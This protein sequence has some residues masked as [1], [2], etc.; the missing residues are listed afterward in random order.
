MLE[1][2]TRYRVAQL[3][4][5]GTMTN[6]P[7]RIAP[8]ATS[9]QKALDEITTAAG[10]TLDLKPTVQAAAMLLQSATRL[11]SAARPTD[12]RGSA[13]L[14]QLL[15]RLTHRLNSR[16]Y[17]KA[18]RFDQDP[19]ANV[20][21]LPLLA[22]AR[23]LATMSK[24]SETYGFLET[25]LLRGRNAVEASLTDAGATSISISRRP[26][27]LD[28]QHRIAEAPGLGRRAAASRRCLISLSSREGEDVMRLVGS[29]ILG[30]VLWLGWLLLIAPVTAY[31]QGGTVT[32]TLSGRV[33]DATGG[34]LPGVAVTVVNAGTNQSRT[35]TSS[36]DG[37]FGFAGLTP[38]KYA[39]SAELQGFATFAQTDIVL[40]V[41]AAVDLKV[42]M[43]VSNVSES[44]TVTG[45]SAIVESAKTALTT[46]ISRDQIETLPTNRRN[47]LDFALLTPGVAEDVRTAGQ[48]IGLKFAGARGKE[49][50]LL[51]D[52]L[53]NTD[54]SFTFPK[55]KYSQDSI[56]EFQVV[57]LGAAAEFGR[58][59]GGIVSAVT[60]SG[61]NTFSGTGYGFFR[62]KSL[63]AQ[64][65]L[66]KTQGLEKSDFDRQQWGGSAGGPIARDRVFFFGAADRSTENTPY[67]NG[68]TQENAAI[69]G[70][71]PAD[72]GNINQFLNDTFTMGKVTFAANTNN[73]ITAQYAMTFDVISNFQ[74]AFGTRSRTGKWDS[75]DHTALFQWMRV[76]G[77]GQWLH[78]LKVGYMPRR[79]HNTNRDE[80]GA[81][82]TADGQLRSSFAPSV[83]ITRVANFGSGRVTLDMLTKP[84]QGVY[85][86]TV[87]KN[88][89]S[90]KFGVDVM[91]VNFLY[92]RYQGPDSGTYIFGS[93]AAYLSGAYTTYTQSFG[94][95]GLGRY[96]TYVAGYA[97]TRGR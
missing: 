63:N 27:R 51:V 45:E 95:P 62:N 15:V 91:G 83:T 75:T 28:R 90:L 84:V 79:F 46:V 97:R 82:L 41:G 10:G 44:V 78:D 4:S 59:I 8:I 14:N 42:T 57:N 38:G 9:F 77:Q 54:E 85:S 58:A 43:R 69:I 71:P 64:D 93:L 5:L 24:E 40:N 80:G 1:L 34:V 30:N 12:A 32:A 3:Y 25:E 70:L 67:N 52:G 50:S 33:S 19:A 49:G 56:A 81:P 53:W 76:G 74:A 35:V 18:G 16:L 22:R 37:V 23:E 29:R 73:T 47:Y 31:G 48:G 92:L 88:Q 65:F 72:V 20:P 86:A 96:H 26:A 21:I 68:I 89:H 36:A 60:R 7:L 94:P 55:I 13:A 11:D 6:L 39:L 17:T 61:T 66:S 87:F 2:D